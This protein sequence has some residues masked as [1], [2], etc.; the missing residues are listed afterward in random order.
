MSRRTV[1]RRGLGAAGVLALVGGLEELFGHQD[2]GEVISLRHHG[3]SGDGVHD[4]SAAFQRALNAASAGATVVG[5]PSANYLLN[6]A[7]PISFPHDHV[8]L[9]LRGAA[10]QAGAEAGSETEHILLVS[11]RTGV[12][13]ANARITA[14]LSVS[15]TIL[16]TLTLLV[17]RG[18]SHCMVERVKA[19]CLGATFVWVQTGAHHVVR[20]NDVLRG[21]IAA[22]ATDGLEISN[23]RLRD[24]GGDAIN[25][26]GYAGAPSRDLLCVGNDIRGHGR[27][28]IEDY[29]SGGPNSTIRSVI[30]AN[31]I[32]PPAPSTTTGFGISAVGT[33]TVIDANIITDAVTYGIEASGEMSE[34]TH[35]RLAWTLSAATSAYGATGVIVNSSPIGEREAGSVIANTVI[36]AAIGIRVVGRPYVGRVA[37]AGNKVSDALSVGIDAS[38]SDSGAGSLGAEVS[39]NTVDFTRPAATT[40]T[41]GERIGIR[42][43]NGARVH[44]NTII[45]SKSARADGANELPLQ[46]GPSTFIGRNYVKTGGAS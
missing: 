33:Q 14:P 23:N 20:A 7:Q 24:S 6:N 15:D 4:D 26:V 40:G 29:A 5:E 18:G 27:I 30:R 19:N 44:G 12:R 43:G 32:G 9:D 8:T 41:A 1:L 45:Y 16:S 10:V 25:S 35:N 46:L 28:A 38:L 17:I 13:I 21:S 11:Q 2:S 36:G 39:G 3:A 31:R 42:A 22:W 34:I 37:I